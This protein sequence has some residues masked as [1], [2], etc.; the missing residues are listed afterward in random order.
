MREGRERGALLS[1]GQ[2]SAWALGSPPGAPRWRLL[3]RAPS[4]EWAGVVELRDQAMSISSSLG[5]WSEIEGRRY[6]H[7]MDPRTGHPLEHGLEAAVVAP[8]AT[9]AEVLSTALLVLGEEEG[10]ALLE[11]L[12]GCEGML[13]D[14]L[15][16]VAMTSGWLKATRFV[17]TRTP[18]H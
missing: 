6:G 15:G 1:F 10:L 8:D 11:A 7:V 17:E 4:G 3:L 12:D 9:R 2:S 16:G 5:Q 14:E 18:E 13:V